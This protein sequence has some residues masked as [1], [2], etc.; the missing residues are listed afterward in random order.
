MKSAS[1]RKERRRLELQISGSDRGGS[2]KVIISINRRSFNSNKPVS[3]C[4]ITSVR[5]ADP[6]MDLASA[7]S[8]KKDVQCFICLALILLDISFGKMKVDCHF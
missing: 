4:F 8:Y 1:S 5:A 7:A 2:I 6:Q 3:V